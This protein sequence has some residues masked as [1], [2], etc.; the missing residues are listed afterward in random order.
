MPRRS[1]GRGGRVPVRIRPAGRGR[2]WQTAGVGVL[3]IHHVA[4]CVRDL[5]E[6]LAFYRDILG[7][8]EMP[9]RPDFGF[10]GAWLRAGAHQIH[11]YEMPEANP[12]RRQHV[13]LAVDD[14]DALVEVLESRGVAVDRRPHIPGA[15]R[16]AFIRDPTG[17]RIELNQ[18]E[19]A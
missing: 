6:A 5:D 12:E 15:G 7:F 9:E 2:R 4:L 11:L 16:Q 19:P 18:P 10:A 3:G 17:N 14:L 1:P 13:A 8:P